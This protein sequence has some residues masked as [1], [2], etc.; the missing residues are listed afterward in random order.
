MTDLSKNIMISCTICEGGIA[1][2]SGVVHG[3]DDDVVYGMEDV[4]Y[5]M[6]GVVYG[7]E[8]VV[9]GMD[10]VVHGMDDVVYG[11]GAV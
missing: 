8:D 5:G 3:M 2:G 4:V 11:S 1:Q 6:D 9:Y 10:G 7:M